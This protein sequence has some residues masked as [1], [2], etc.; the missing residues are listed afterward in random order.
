M[1]RLALAEIKRDVAVYPGT[2]NKNSACAS[3][4]DEAEDRDA[5][6]VDEAAD[7]GLVVF[8]ATILLSLQKAAAPV[9]GDEPNRSSC[10]TV[11][12]FADPRFGILIMGSA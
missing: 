8:L 3:P 6:L 12:Y 4:A 2:E 9:L 5:F 10:N 1:G 11:D 7:R